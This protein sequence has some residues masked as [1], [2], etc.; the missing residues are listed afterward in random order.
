MPPN[1]LYQ[2]WRVRF[3][4][5]QAPHRHLAENHRRSAPQAELS[6]TAALRYALRLMSKDLPTQPSRAS[7]SAT[8]N[9]AKLE[10]VRIPHKAR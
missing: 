8:F 9:V 3:G 2:A 6:Q 1:G 5:V 7:L 4:D 10:K